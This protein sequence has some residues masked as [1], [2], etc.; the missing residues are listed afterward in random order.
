MKMTTPIS[1]FIHSY[2]VKHPLRLHMPGHKG[3]LLMGLE[4]YDITEAVDF[5]TAYLSGY[6]A[7]K[8]DV[9]AEAS[10]ERANQRIRRSTEEAF[11]STVQG[12]TPVT[13]VT[14]SIKLENGVSKVEKGVF[15]AEMKVEII[16]DGPV[17]IV[18]DT[19]IWDKR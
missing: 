6:L 16:N 12:Y 19:D 3:V 8:Y 13:P 17:T 11:A 10:I 9:D 5:R 14:S 2:V 15:G 18:M 1:D 4:P 7:D